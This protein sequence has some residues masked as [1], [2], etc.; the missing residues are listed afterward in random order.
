M[1]TVRLTL[2]RKVSVD[3]Y[4]DINSRVY[5]DLPEDFSLS[6]TKAVDRLGDFLS[7]A[8]EA[9]LSA[10]LPKTTKNDFLLSSF[11]APNGQSKTKR[12]AIEVQMNGLNVPITGLRVLK[13][14][15]ASNTYD[16]DF[17]GADWVED[18]EDY[19]F[20]DQDLGT[21]DYTLSK[22]IDSWDQQNVLARPLPAFY[23]PMP[24]PIG[25][26]TMRDLRFWFNSFLLLEKAFCDIGWELD[27]PHLERGD[28]ANHTAYL[29]TDKWYSYPGKKAF[30]YAN[31]EIVG[32]ILFQ[33]YSEFDIPWVV[34]E[35]DQQ[36]WNRNFNFL[37]DTIV[38]LTEQANTPITLE[39][40]VT[41]D[42]TLPPY[43]T[44]DTPERLNVLLLK[45][46]N[47][48]EEFLVDELLS[49]HPVDT[50]NRQFVVKHLDEN[51]L[52]GDS[53]Q[54]I[55]FYAVPFTVNKMDWRF[56]PD[57]PYLQTGDLIPYAKVIDTE[58]TAMEFLLGVAQLFNAKFITDYAN[59]R[60]RMLPPY[61]YTAQGTGERIEGFYR[62]GEGAI[63]FRAQTVSKSIRWVNKSKNRNRYIVYK[64]AEGE[65][66][67][68]EELGLGRF[69]R[70]VDLG[71]GLNKEDDEENTI[72]QATYIGQRTYTGG[73]DAG[74]IRLVSL[75]RSTVASED[76]DDSRDE[77]GFRIC[78]Y[79]GF[80]A[81]LNSVFR[82]E[83]AV[84]NQIPY[85]NQGVSALATVPSTP[86]SFTGSTSNIWNLFYRRETVLE[87]LETIYELF[88]TG[89]DEA[90]QKIDFRK[91][92]IIRGE[93]GD[94]ELQPLAVKDHRLGSQVPLLVTGKQIVC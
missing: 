88:L 58:L 82:F 38:L 79:Y 25:Q 40:S 35:D 4:G 75:T 94:W 21:F 49:G 89:G 61:D 26:F 65:D 28:G 69:D 60:V 32:P 20:H 18:L 72:F 30:G 84:Y 55:F 80:V 42:V 37:R 56:A 91:S 33:E 19:L 85:L 17:F 66:A 81:V 7:V 83:G 73:E 43:T 29:S 52:Q 16:V 10:A 11:G 53:Y 31:L 27:C 63:D 93:F 59:K 36:V 76:G 50:I 46:R 9:A 45:M 2:P 5:L 24:N 67:R 39:I 41:I 13:Y 92:L 47:G 86:I 23:R 74:Q 14:D 57:P 8:Q 12:L 62:R 87:D 64:F 3:L 90:Y 68:I 77:L 51:A 54:W 70:R 71:K 15:P 6:L 78:N 48:V 1:I 34:V 22:V 44:F